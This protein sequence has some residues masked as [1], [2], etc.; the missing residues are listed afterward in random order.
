MKLLTL[1][2]AKSRAPTPA[3]GAALP[4]THRHSGSRNDSPWY[5][6]PPAVANEGEIEEWVR[7]APASETAGVLLANLI[8]E[9]AALG[10]PSRMARSLESKLTTAI[11][12][13]ASPESSST[14]PSVRQLE[15]FVRRVEAMSGARIHKSDA[16]ALVEQA[17]EII[18][19]I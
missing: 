12:L 15:S 7:D 5:D 17:S 16:T 4:V 11:A 13:L 8:A 2:S 3:A 9:V 1:Q 14:S 18:E 6:N 19:R 10:L